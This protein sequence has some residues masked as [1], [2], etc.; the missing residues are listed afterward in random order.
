MAEKVLNPHDNAAGRYLLRASDSLR[1]K[2]Y[3]ASVVEWAPSGL[4]VKLRYPRNKYEQWVEVDEYGPL[5]VEKL[6]D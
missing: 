3:E 4:R 5:I 6:P 2:P 1:H